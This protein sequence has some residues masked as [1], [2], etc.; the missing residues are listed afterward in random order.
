MAFKKLKLKAKKIKDEKKAWGLLPLNKKIR[1]GQDSIIDAIKNF[2]ENKFFLSKFFKIIPDIDK[3][4]ENCTNEPN[5]SDPIWNP[6]EIK[7]SPIPACKPVN[8]SGK[9]I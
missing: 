2:E 4:D 3:I 6:K 8:H 5:C 1:I 7:T 9:R